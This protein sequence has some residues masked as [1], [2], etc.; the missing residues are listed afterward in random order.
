MLFHHV[1]PSQFP[2]PPDGESRLLVDTNGNLNVIGPDRTTQVLSAVSGGG[3]TLSPAERSAFELMDAAGLD[4]LTA[5]NIAALSRLIRQ[6]QDIKHFGTAAAPFVNT[7]AFI[8]FEATSGGTGNALVGPWGSVPADACAVELWVNG[9]AVDDYMFFATET[10]RVAQLGN[11]AANNAANLL[12]ARWVSSG[13]HAI[14]PFANVGTVPTTLRL[15][16]GKTPAR[17]QGRWLSSSQGFPYLLASPT[18]HLLTGA[19]GVL[20]FNVAS[21]AQFPV[22]YVGNVFQ[23]LG[24]GPV[25]YTR[26]GTTPSV[27]QG[28]ILPTGTYYFDQNRH[29]VSLAAL[30]FY[31]P[32][33][34]NI[35]GNSLFNA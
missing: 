31:L 23:V 1:N 16:V 6:G 26:D 19:S 8:D 28:D 4:T 34:T 12:A 9:T 3:T 18:M 21:T 33:G 11:F 29:G 27:T 5:T 25:R 22:G 20:Q 14:I 35:L 17:I 24:T 13:A 32:A 2:D 15:A 7:G 30:K 10:G